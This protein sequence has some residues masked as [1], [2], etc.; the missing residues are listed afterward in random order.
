MPYLVTC[1]HA[2]PC[3]AL[4]CRAW[5]CQTL[6]ALPEYTGPCSTIH[7]RTLAALPENACPKLNLPRLLSATETELAL[8]CCTKPYLHYLALPYRFP[9]HQTL[10]ELTTSYLHNLAALLRAAPHRTL[11]AM[12]CL[13]VP[14]RALPCLLSLTRW[15]YPWYEGALI[16]GSK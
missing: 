11:P 12:S 4:P 1:R 15:R 16:K 9:A 13:A 14:D 6:P 2:L 5:S 10:P 7:K 3:H 8:T